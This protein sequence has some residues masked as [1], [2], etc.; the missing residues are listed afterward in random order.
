MERPSSTAVALIAFAPIFVILSPL[1]V[2]AMLIVFI[3]EEW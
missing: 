1:L 3:Y 2:A